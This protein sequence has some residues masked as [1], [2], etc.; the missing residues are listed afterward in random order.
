[1]LLLG[2]AKWPP[3]WPGFDFQTRRHMWVEFVV[4]SLLAPRSISPGTPD[5]PSPQK[6]TFLNSNSIRNSTA[7]GLSVAR[8]HDDHLLSNKKN[9]DEELIK[10]FLQSLESGEIR[11][12]PCL[13]VTYFVN[14]TFWH[15]RQKPLNLRSWGAV[16]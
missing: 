5:F 3:K 8:L 7:T 9:I 4:G 2:S 15:Y 16:R 14:M 10:V 6:P 12:F 13:I 11:I 1:M